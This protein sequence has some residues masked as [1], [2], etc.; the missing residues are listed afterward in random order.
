M[1]PRAAIMWTAVWWYM[2]KARDFK[3]F[4]QATYEKINFSLDL[5]KTQILII[6]LNEQ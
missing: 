5:S 2:G 3:T 6:F 1:P 4:P